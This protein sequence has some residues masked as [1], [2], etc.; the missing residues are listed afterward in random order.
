MRKAVL[1]GGFII[2]IMG[3]AQAQDQYA[4]SVNINTSNGLGQN[5]WSSNIKRVMKADQNEI[6]LFEGA[7]GS[8]TVS[9]SVHHVDEERMLLVAGSDFRPHENTPGPLVSANLKSISLKKGEKV[10]YYP[11]GKNEED[12]EEGILFYMEITI[13][14]MENENT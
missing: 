9:L 1:W 7:N 12:N 6:F 11:L 2:L 14:S 5:V 3:A 13:E 10:V 8:L 4:L